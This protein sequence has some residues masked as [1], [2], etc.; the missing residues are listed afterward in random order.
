MSTEL[1]RAVG[2]FSSRS[3]AET[4]LSELRESGFNMDK[5]SVVNENSDADKMQGATVNDQKGDQIAE[6]TGAGATAGGITGGTLGLIGSLGVLAI[7]GVGPIAEVGILLANTV[8]GGIIGAAG[9][10]LVGA[11]VGWGVP[12]DRAKYY[13]DRVY[14]SGDYL[15][16]VEGDAATIQDAQAVLRNNQIRDWQTFS[17]SGSSYQGATGD[18]PAYQGS[19]TPQPPM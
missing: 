9:G 10:G 6:A 8:L 19:A 4:A 13:N 7:P 3:D 16:M 12:E 5:V 2:L 1:Q 18:T 17:P 15:I 14:D 11:L